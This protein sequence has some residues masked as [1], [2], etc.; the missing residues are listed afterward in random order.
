[1]RRS[2]PPWPKR[3]PETFRSG[4]AGATPI[5][6]PLLEK[7]SHPGWDIP[8][9]RELKREAASQLGTV[10]S[11]NHYVDVFEAEHDGSIWLGVHFGSRGLGHKIAS[12]Y[13]KLAGGKNGIDVE[14]AVL[15]AESDLGREYLVAMD[16]AG[17]Y[18]YAGREWV[19]HTIVREFMH[20]GITDAVHNHHNYAWKEQ[21]G[22]AEQYVVRKGATPLYPGQRGFVGGSMGDISVI[23]KG[24][25]EGMEAGL[26]NSTIHGSGRVMSRTQA[27][28]KSRWVKGRKVSQG[29]GLVDENAW[30]ETMRERGIILLGAGADE[31]PPVYRPLRSVLS[32]HQDTFEIETVLLPRIVVMAGSG[33]HDPYKD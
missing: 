17:L 29:G 15:A 2:C 19:V 22:G 30:R 32:A 12:H 6:H 11:G 10:G 20:A 9:V 1:M 18:A 7:D 5:E 31:M 26:L 28:G 25:P 16:L 8:F 4:W 23:L 33:E 3:L 13:T 24:K 21:V 27:A 14:P